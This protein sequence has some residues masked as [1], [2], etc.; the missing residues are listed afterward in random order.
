MY[1][2]QWLQT[3][4]HHVFALWDL[5]SESWLVRLKMWMCGFLEWPADFSFILHW[6]TRSVNYY[7]H[8]Q[9]NVLY[10]P[11]VIFVSTGVQ[12][13]L[14]ACYLL[15]KQLV[16]NGKRTSGN[17][18]MFRA[19]TF[20]LIFSANHNYPINANDLCQC[21][22]NLVPRLSGNEVGVGNAHNKKAS[23]F[24]AQALRWLTSLGHSLET[25]R[26]SLLLG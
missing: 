4:S 8:I 1:D 18:L 22:Y 21:R 20:C 24:R 5:Y 11:T 17:I 10:K 15:R 7:L 26:F 12:L 6:Q 16:S 13:I 25:S 23:T 14:L 3:L 9:P 19:Q 2:K